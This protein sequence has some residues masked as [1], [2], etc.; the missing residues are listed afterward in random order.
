MAVG[1]GASVGVVGLN[2]SLGNSAVAWRNAAAQ[3]TALWGY[4]VSLGANEAAQV[5]A[6]AAMTGWQNA[7]TDPQAFW[8]AAN[9][10]FAL[11][12]LY[13]GQINQATANNYDT[14]LASARGGG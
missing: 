8:T 1:M 5:A 14:A 11:A 13:Y 3:A 12:Q 7:S 6:L 2:T 4:I 9:A 10:E